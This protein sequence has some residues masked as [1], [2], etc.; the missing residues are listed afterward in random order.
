MFHEMFH[1]PRNTGQGDDRAVFCFDDE[2]G[3]GSNGIFYSDGSLWYVSLA[4][5]VFR[6]N[7]AKAPI[8]LLHLFPKFLPKLGLDTNREGDSLS[9]RIV[10]RRPQST[11]GDDDIGIRQAVLN[12]LGDSFYIVSNGCLAE[13]IDSLFTQFTR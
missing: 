5:I 2:C 6:R 11:R 8:P 4:F 13:Q 12:R 3:C 10:N 9:S 1:L 7:T